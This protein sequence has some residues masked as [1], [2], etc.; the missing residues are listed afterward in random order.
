MVD[1]QTHV[2]DV[3]SQVSADVNEQ[4]DAWTAHKTEAG[5]VYYYNT[6]TGESTYDKPPGFKGE[7]F[8]ILVSLKQLVFSF[9]NII[10]FYPWF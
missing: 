7:V 9:P 4:S 3:S 2:H 10:N 1:E 6:L 8:T 5:V